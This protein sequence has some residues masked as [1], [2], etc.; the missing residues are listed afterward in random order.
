LAKQI[1]QK[2]NMQNNM[3]IQNNMWIPKAHNKFRHPFSAPILNW[4]S[5][6]AKKTTQNAPYVG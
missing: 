6:F 1:C 2:N 3:C 5:K 4:Q